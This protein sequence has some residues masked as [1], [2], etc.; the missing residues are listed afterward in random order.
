[1][2]SITKIYGKRFFNKLEKNAKGG[3]EHTTS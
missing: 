2:F 3:L 1:V